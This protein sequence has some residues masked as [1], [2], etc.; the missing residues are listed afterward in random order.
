[1]REQLAE[2]TPSGGEARVVKI[3]D[4]LPSKNDDDLVVVYCD[5]DGVI[6]FIQDA[7]KF[8]ILERS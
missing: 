3:L 6:G 5:T 8:R 4:I 2:Y 7:S 1:M